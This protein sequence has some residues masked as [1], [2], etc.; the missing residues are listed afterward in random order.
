MDGVGWHPDSAWANM[1]CDSSPRTPPSCSTGARQASCCVVEVREASTNDEAEIAALYVASRRAAW[2]GLIDEAYL[3]GLDVE[4]EGHDLFTN[5]APSNAGWRLLVAEESGKI[6]G[7]V[8]FVAGGEYGVGHVGALFVSPERF[9]SGIGTSL[10]ASAAAALRDAGCLE[11]ILW[12]LEEDRSLLEFYRER[13]WV[14]DGSTQT[15]E[16]DQRRTAFRLRTSLSK[17]PG[18]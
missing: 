13:G 16:L 4:E 11:A 10:L 8:T 17:L 2:R 5:L 18:P 3:S 9:R 1:P 12:S 6:V 7:F 14:P 15:I